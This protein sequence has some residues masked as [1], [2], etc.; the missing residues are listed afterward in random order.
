MGDILGVVEEGSVGSKVKHGVSD[1][2]LCC[3]RRQ[4]GR[5]S[6][7]SYIPP[8]PFQLF[9]FWLLLF[10]PGQKM[11]HVA[12]TQGE[13]L[14]KVQ[15]GGL[16]FWFFF[17]PPAGP[18]GSFIT[19]LTQLP[20]ALQKSNRRRASS[21]LLLCIDLSEGRLVLSVPAL[22]FLPTAYFTPGT[23]SVTAGR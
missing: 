5:L 16:F 14:M 11:R 22:L 19:T 20:P 21:R 2:T 13:I 8:H 15:A 10:V 9:F 1:V 12:L 4:P 3:P 23:C 17:S 7:V 6:P 18:A